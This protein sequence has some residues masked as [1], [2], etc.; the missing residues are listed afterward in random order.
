M[1]RLPCPGLFAG[2]LQV[3]TYQSELEVQR[4]QA[5]RHN[6]LFNPSFLFKSPKL[7]IV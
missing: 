7:S 5:A 1:G 4:V 3:F 2:A 6:L